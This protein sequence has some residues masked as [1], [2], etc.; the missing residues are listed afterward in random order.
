MKFIGKIDDIIFDG[1]ILVRTTFK[2]KIGT[3]VIN[4][5]KQELGKIS[6]IIGPVKKPYITIKP[7]KELKST[8]NLIGTDVYI[9]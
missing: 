2:P 9:I 5:H 3:I 7:K 8:F 1:R 4:K 6:Q